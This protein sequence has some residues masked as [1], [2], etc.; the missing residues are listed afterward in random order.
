MS[1]AF[2]FMKILPLVERL[3]DDTSRLFTKF[4]VRA[5]NSGDPNEFVKTALRK[6]LDEPEV[7]KPKV[8]EPDFAKVEYTVKDVK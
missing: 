4:V 5:L 3:Q 7:V 6:V 2:D 8:E 1:M